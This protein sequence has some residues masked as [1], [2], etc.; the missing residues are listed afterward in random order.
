M[1]PRIFNSEATIAE[2]HGTRQTYWNGEATDQAPQ[3]IATSTKDM[4]TITAQS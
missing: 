3:K 4:S 1:R 2:L